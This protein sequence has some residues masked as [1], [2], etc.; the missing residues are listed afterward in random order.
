MNFFVSIRSELLKAKRTS[1]LYL[2]L[3]AAAF[4]PV[5]FLLE[6][7]FDALEPETIKNPWN[8]FFMD[9]LRGF[10][11]IILPAY[12]ILSCTLLL[13]IEYRYHTWKQ[14][15]VSPQPKAQLFLS[16]FL[17]I[18]FFI[19][20]L[21]VVF[22]LLM[23]IS[24]G[25]VQLVHPDLLVLT[26]KADWSLYFTTIAYAYV[27][28]LGISAIQYWLSMRFKNFIA[29]IGIGLALW[30]VGGML[31]FEMKW[32]HADKFPFSYPILHLF[33]VLKSGTTFW[34]WGSF[35]YLALFMVLG[36]MDFKRK[37]VKA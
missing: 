23:L 33:P 26:G 2:C 18:H 21:L 16:K 22:T 4:L 34:A 9:G 20:L 24:A 31:L 15:L 8:A 27:T 11:F 14:V 30:L 1:T 3:I 28:I 13:Q 25:I 29:P 12:V 19:L 35:G 6:T 7:S 17:V 32:E 5:T 10:C 37:E 36:F